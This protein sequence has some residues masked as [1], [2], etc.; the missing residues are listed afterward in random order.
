MGRNWQNYLIIFRY[1]YRLCVPFSK[2]I[3]VFFRICLLLENRAWTML[4]ASLL[5]CTT[6]KEIRKCSI[7][8]IL[9]FLESWNW[10]AFRNWESILHLK[11]LFFK[12]R[13][14]IRHIFFFFKTAKQ[15]YNQ[16]IQQVCVNQSN[17]CNLKVNWPKAKCK[18]EH[19]GLFCKIGLY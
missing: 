2:I 16:A 13:G 4:L 12:S 7:S 15:A 5:Y 8:R 9:V 11:W 17:I 3:L 18:T 19:L 14:K 6:Q 10:K 1:P